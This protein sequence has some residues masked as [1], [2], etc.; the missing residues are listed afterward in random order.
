MVCT[1]CGTEFIVED[2]VNNFQTI[3]E[4][5]TT[6]NI[7]KHV[8]G[9]DGM[10]ISDVVRNG[11]VFISLGEFGKAE[12]LYME[13][14]N[15]NPADWRGWFGMV[16]IKTKNFSDTDDREHLE[17]L[18]KAKKVARDEQREEIDKQYK[19]YALKIAKEKAEKDEFFRR[20]KLIEEKQR[21]E[22]EK[23][24]KKKTLIIITVIAILALTF[25]IF[26]RIG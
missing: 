1:Y 17:F 11:D 9:K 12:N 2:V 3:N 19:E 14:I 18:S 25:L 20:R 21:L 23:K 10:D 22:R 26:T 15:T 6:Q 4:Y 13:V 16:K 7:V 24:D 8:Y 5:H